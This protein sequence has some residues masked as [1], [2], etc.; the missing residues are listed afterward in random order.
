MN[1][2]ELLHIYGQIHEHGEVYIVGNRK[3]LQMLKDLI[4][5][6]LERDTEDDQA[7]GKAMV[8]DGEGF[9]VYVICED[10]AWHENYWEKLGV[11]YTGQS[12]QETR[13]DACWPWDKEDKP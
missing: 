9:E 4:A 13:A 10:S 7:Q 5:E 8:T 1:E 2:P 12:S 6:A 11:P 3:A